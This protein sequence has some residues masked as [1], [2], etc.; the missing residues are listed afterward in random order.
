MQTNIKLFFLSLLTWY[1]FT[2]PLL[3]TLMQTRQCDWQNWKV[4]LHMDNLALSNRYFHLG[5]F[6]IWVTF[7]YDW[8]MRLF[9]SL[10]YLFFLPPGARER[11]AGRR[12]ILGSRL[13]PTNGSTAL[14]LWNRYFHSPAVNTTS[15]VIQ[16]LGHCC[17]LS[18]VV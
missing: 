18:S 13:A 7:A 4:C 2:C 17:D 9:I 15:I 14:P 5:F 3:R 11:G 10:P 6:V 8:G 1:V 16:G 12:E